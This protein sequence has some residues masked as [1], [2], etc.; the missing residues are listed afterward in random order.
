[1]LGGVKKHT[2]DCQNKTPQTGWL[3]QQKL[4][5]LTVLESGVQDQ[6]VGR[7]GLSSGFSP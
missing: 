1:M 7:F 2:P 5:F 6:G 4:I 3:K